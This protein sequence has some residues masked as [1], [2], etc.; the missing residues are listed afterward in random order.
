MDENLIELHCCD[1]LDEN[2]L[3]DELLKFLWEEEKT[4]SKISSFNIKGIITRL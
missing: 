1:P 4:C 3:D 2:A